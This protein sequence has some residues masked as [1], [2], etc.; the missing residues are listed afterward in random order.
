M[1]MDI[2]VE[3]TA[4]VLVEIIGYFIFCVPASL[5][6]MDY[7]TCKYVSNSFLNKIQIDELFLIAHF[8]GFII[9]RGRIC[10]SESAV[11]IMSV[12]TG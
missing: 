1:N 12:G 6:I 10:H 5:R 3:M 11:F 8:S 2:T 9:R 4:P 7:K